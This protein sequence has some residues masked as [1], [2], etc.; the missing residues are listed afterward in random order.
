APRAGGTDYAIA[1]SVQ[2]GGV[3]CG[4][5]GGGACDRFEFVVLGESGSDGTREQKEVLDHDARGAKSWSGRPESNRRHRPWKGHTVP[6]EL[7][8]PAGKSYCPPEP[9]LLSNNSCKR[10]KS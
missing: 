6:A 1:F 7:L 10:Q 3:G 5:V 2:Q 4:H 9:P 8:P